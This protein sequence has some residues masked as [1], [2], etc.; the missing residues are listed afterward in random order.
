[1]RQVA[2][3]HVGTPVLAWQAENRASFI[4]DKITEG[5]ANDELADDLGFSLADIQEARQVRAIADMARALPLEEEVKAK[6]ENPRAKVFSTLNRVI[7]SSV[8]RE[9]FCV[10]KSADHGILGRTSKA[11]FIKGFSRLVTDVATG[12]QS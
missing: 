2:G 7:D 9:F 11:E 12:K 1:D 3:R 6:L 10:E 4:L 8:G 5:Y